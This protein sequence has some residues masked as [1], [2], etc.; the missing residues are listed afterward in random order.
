MMGVRY[1]KIDISANGCSN[2]DFERGKWNEPKTMTAFSV[3]YARDCQGPLLSC[4]HLSGT[5]AQVRKQDGGLAMTFCKGFQ[6]SNVMY[7]G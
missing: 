1:I 2:A 3:R 6:K 7:Q 4:L 5:Q